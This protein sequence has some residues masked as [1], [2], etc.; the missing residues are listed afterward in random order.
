[1]FMAMFHLLATFWILFLNTG[2]TGGD[3]NTSGNNTA[4]IGNSDN[5]QQNQNNQQRQPDLA[6][7]AANLIQRHGSPD[8][9]L[10][11]LM[12]ENF[13]LRD[14]RRDLERRL[15]ADGAVVLAG[16]DVKRWQTYQGLGA[17]DTIQTA[18]AERDAAKGELTTLQRSKA[19]ADAAQASG[20][21]SSVLERLPKADTLQFTIKD[22]NEN[23]QTVRRAYVKDGDT[24]ELLTTYAEREWKDF[25][26][27]LALE[28]A[29]RPAGT[30]FVRQQAGGTAPITDPVTRHSKNMG[31]AL[32]K[33]RT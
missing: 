1:M 30:G 13:Q 6:Q 18:L 15:P 19:I 21:K 20:Y 9:A 16:D 28:S 32:P 31:Y 23:G 11:L 17:P 7:Q 2:N 25:L 12:Q 29:P 5:T 14:A 24:E 8:A 10:I 3:A 33:A 22:E 26:P 27:A 4:N